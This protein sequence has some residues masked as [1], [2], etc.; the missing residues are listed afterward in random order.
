MHA[1]KQQVLRGA[2]SEM[3]L[4]SHTQGTARNT[5]RVTRFGD[6][7]WFEGMHCHDLTESA[8]DKPVMLQG[9]SV[10]AEI[11]HVNAIQH[12]LNQRLLQPEC[13]CRL[14][15]QLWRGF[16]HFAGSSMQRAQV[17]QGSG[18]WGDH[19]T[20]AAAIGLDPK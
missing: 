18:Q 5:E 13:G 17:H 7:Q 1:A 16:H 12:R 11:P 9:G 6:V 4:T 15:C 19:G 14:H 2:D 10:R 20:P 3:L 8:D